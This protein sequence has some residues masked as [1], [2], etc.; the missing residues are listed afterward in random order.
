MSI[1]SHHQI[2]MNYFREIENNIIPNLVKEKHK[3]KQKIKNTLDYNT[4]FLYKDAINNIN[5]KIRNIKY[6]EKHYLLDNMHILEVYYNNIKLIN[7][8]KHNINNTLHFFNKQTINE[9]NFSN[10]QQYWKN[11][12]KCN[13]I[14]Y[15][16]MICSF[17]NGE[18]VQ[19]F[20]TKCF[21]INKLLIDNSC[22]TN[23]S[24]NINNI[25]T[26]NSYKRIIHLKKILNQ[27]NGKNTMKIPNTIIDDI[28]NRMKIQ[29]IE[30]LNY[31]I[32]YDILK[33]LKL[34]KYFYQINHILSI[35]NVK[36]DVMDY[37]LIDSI[38][39]VF[40]LL[41]EPFNKYRVNKRSNFFS[42][43]FIIYKIL[44]YLN[45]MTFIKKILKL[46]NIEKERKQ[47]ELFDLCIKS[48]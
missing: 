27:M 35:F 38:C 20:C 33:K 18:I 5:T 2:K 30:L 15:D 44:E 39:H 29:K 12:G 9:L 6:Q 26:D 1:D 14:Y 22:N 32:L 16:P 36:I 24:S 40:T 7:E 45:E 17:C 3:I 23:N 47:N 25:I 43:N 46:K 28:R 10:N 11:N 8:N 13:I 48:I 41:Q 37:T 4:V 21:S 31:D 42:Y 34:I 19:E